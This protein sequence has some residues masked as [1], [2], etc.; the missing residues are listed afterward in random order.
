MEENREKDLLE[1]VER[2]TRMQEQLMSVLTR[3]RKEHEPEAEREINLIDAFFAILK[4]WWI[5]LLCTVVCAGAMLGYC[6]KTYEPSYRATAK[7]Y[8]NNN[9]V[10]IGSTQV[11]ITSSDLTASQSLVNTYCEILRTYLVL[12]QVG[13][14]LEKQG[15]L[16]YSYRNLVGKISCSSVNNTEIFSITVVDGDPERAIDIVNTI[17]DVLPDQIALV[18]DG[19]SARTVDRAQYAFIV[20]NGFAKKIMIAAV[21][22]FVVSAAV[23]FAVNYLLNDT[24]ENSDWL[25]STYSSVPILGEVPDINHTDKK[26]YYYYQQGGKKDE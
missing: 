2:Q 13:R 17:V 7:M 18:I 9:A 10:T 24:V 6:W 5:I 23:V 3:D 1:I 11:S 22:G 21:V 19:S 8:V 14:D 16:G 4:G 12:D 26:G 20:D 25:S 15:Y